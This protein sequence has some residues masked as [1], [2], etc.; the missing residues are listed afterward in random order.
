[1]KFK[2]ENVNAQDAV[3]GT[4]LQGYVTASYHQLV[5]MF[6]EPTYTAEDFGDDKVTCEWVINYSQVD[7]NGDEDYG[8]FTLYDWKGS[9]PYDPAQEFTV[10]VGGNGFNDKWAAQTAFE[11]F[12]KTDTKYCSDKGS[13]LDNWIEFAA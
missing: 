7:E 8:T 1:M 10:N 9:K 11:I 2:Y 4:S 13:M 12:D 6:G 3:V 5:E